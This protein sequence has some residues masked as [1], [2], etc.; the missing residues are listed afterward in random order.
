MEQYFLEL[1]YIVIGLI[2]IY[3]GYGIITNKENVNRITSSLFWIILGLL[4]ILPNL[5]IF[6]QGANSEAAPFIPYNVVGVL[7]IVLSIISL[8]KKVNVAKYQTYNI[9]ES[10][11]RGREIGAKIFIPAALIGVLGFVFYG[12]QQMPILPDVLKVGDLGGLGL[13]ILTATIVAFAIT[14][15]KPKGALDEGRILLDQVGPMSILPQILAALGTL[16]TVAG[17]GDYIASTVTYIIPDGNLLIA[18]AVYC[19]AMALFTI[20]MGNAFAAFS[21]ITVGIAIPFLILPGGN[22]A[23]IGALGMTA[24]FCGTLVTPMGANFNIVPASI[25]ELEDRK[26]GVIK[27][28]A[29]IAVILL[30]IHIILMYTLAF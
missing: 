18:S 7:V 3:N 25:L 4:F 20:I 27:Y 1:M 16:F 19:I 6:W 28:Q 15:E 26:W 29:P 17:V 5:Q 14:K 8:L 30:L 13:A 9:E 11:R 21:V 2:A 23:V 22:P 24:G 10:A 12:I